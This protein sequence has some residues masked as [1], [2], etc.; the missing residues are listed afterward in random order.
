MMMPILNGNL[1]Y[2]RRFLERL[3]I[4]VCA[5]ILGGV[6]SLAEHPA[7]MTHASWRR[8]FA[9]EFL[10]PDSVERGAVRAAILMYRLGR[11]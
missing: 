6:E 8:T 2:S 9:N 1:D 10:Y 5:E 11:R 3:N 7:I 4:F